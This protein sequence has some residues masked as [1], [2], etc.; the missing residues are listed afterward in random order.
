MLHIEN[1]PRAAWVIDRLHAAGHAAYAVGGCVRDALLGREPNDWDVCTDAAPERVIEVFGAA[2]CILTGIRHGTVTVRTQGM[3]VEVT[4]FRTEGAYSDGRHPDSVAFVS[5]VREDLSRRDFTVNAM[6]YCD[7]EGLID[8]FGGQ[9]DLE[10]GV[11]RAVGDPY[12]R[13]SEDALRIL[14]LFRFGA[15]LRFALEEETRCAALALRE[16]LSH[17]SVERVFSELSKLLVSENPSAYLPFELA[18][19]C[20]PEAT[21]GGDQ[22][23]ARRLRAMDAAPAELEVRLA[24]LL[25]DEG[26]ATA[27]DALMRLHCSKALTDA[28]AL[29]VRERNITQAEDEK[30]LRVQARRC[31]SRMALED[32]AR[33]KA[34]RDAHIAAGVA[35]GDAQME[36]S[37]AD[38]SMRDTSVAAQGD[39]G[40]LH[41]CAQSFAMSGECCRVAQLAVNG[42]QLRETLGVCGPALGA[43]LA[44]LLERVILEE[45]PNER[46]AL[47]RAAR[48]HLSEDVAAKS[49][50]RE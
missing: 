39:L 43:L 7:G 22:V 31:L 34:L 6:A 48:M 46:D 12:E 37:E 29:L 32:I 11:L 42:G 5:D 47:V 18:R 4:T 38:V 41:A 17:V 20:L 8:P 16:N 10:A 3:S 50:G 23:Y 30:A 26:E 2:S 44:W 1:E 45:L 49:L 35:G 19:V 24:A 33:L 15:K 40:K 14:R 28:V 21:S 36:A 9:G 13:F 27:R 25:C